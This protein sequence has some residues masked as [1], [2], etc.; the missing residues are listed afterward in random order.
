MGF[1]VNSFGEDF[2][3]LIFN[4]EEFGVFC[5]FGILIVFEFLG[6]FV[7]DFV[8]LLV[9]DFIGLILVLVGV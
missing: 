8:F 5:F 4:F 7:L 2:C 6:V 3:F 1:G 9:F